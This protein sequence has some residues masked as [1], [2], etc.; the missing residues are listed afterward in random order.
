M[1]PTAKAATTVVS[2]ASW[3]I[4]GRSAPCPRPGGCGRRRPPRAAPSAARPARVPRQR[5]SA[6]AMPPVA[7][8]IPSPGDQVDEQVA[9]AVVSL[10]ARQREH[11]VAELG[12]QRR[13]DLVLGA[14]IVDQGLDV[15]ALLDRLRRLGG[16]GQRRAADRAHHLVLD[17]G[18]RGLRDTRRRSAAGAAPPA[19]SAAISAADH[20]APAS[21]GLLQQRLHLAA[22]ERLVHRAAPGRRNP[23]RRSITKVSGKPRIP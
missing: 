23:P 22:H 1:K 21:G 17:V 14:A 2:T 3:A 16:Q 10:V 13:L 4:T 20:G 12:G 8:T 19:A 5:T 9:E 7:S 15:L 18:Q 6:K 11:R